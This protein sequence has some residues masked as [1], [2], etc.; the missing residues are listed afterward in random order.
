MTKSAATRRGRGDPPRLR[1]YHSRLARPASRQIASSTCQSTRICA[2]F[3]TSSNVQSAWLA[4]AE[5]STK[6]VPQM[7][8]AP[9][10]PA[11]AMAD[12]AGRFKASS[13]LNKAMTTLESNSVKDCPA[14]REPS[15]E[16]PCD[17]SR[18][19]EFPNHALSQVPARSR[20]L[21]DAPEA[22]PPRRDTQKR[23]GRRPVPEGAFSIAPAA[24]LD[25][26]W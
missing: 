14:S 24:S 3:N 20:P 4:R 25:P 18:F 21:P 6:T 26:Y 2:V 11:A 8:R 9:R 19:R 15:A 5:S 10:R 23:H 12:F 1:A 16:S 7:T 22:R 13:S 17:P